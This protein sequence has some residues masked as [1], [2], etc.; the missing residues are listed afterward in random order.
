MKYA[1]IPPEALQSWAQ[2]NDVHLHGLRISSNI[3]SDDGVS[4]GGGLV[5]TTSHP[6]EPVLLS[7]PRDL[8]L[9][10]EAVVQCA[11]TDKDLRVLMEALEDFIQVGY[12]QVSL[13]STC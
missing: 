6:P 9:S 5:S 11:K 7:I 3:V 10:R 12:E 1:S 4:K 13:P 8:I 2:L